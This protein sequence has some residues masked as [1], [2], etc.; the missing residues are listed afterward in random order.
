VVYC[1]FDFFLRR[2][3][4]Q[5][6]WGLCFCNLVNGFGGDD[7]G[8]RLLFLPGIKRRPIQAIISLCTILVG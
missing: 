6:F 4:Q 5:P 2:I 8:K 3:I 7:F 1:I